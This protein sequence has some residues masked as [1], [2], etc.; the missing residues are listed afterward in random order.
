ML[1]YFYRRL[2]TGSF[3]VLAAVLFTFWRMTTFPIL[4]LQE[5]L[6]AFAEEYPDLKLRDDDFT[7]PQVILIAYSVHIFVYE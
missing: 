2:I 5:L 6:R 1:H 7:N 3:I 4:S